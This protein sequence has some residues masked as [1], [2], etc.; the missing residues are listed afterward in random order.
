M[1]HMR[2]LMAS[3]CM[4]YTLTN[5]Y[6]WPQNGVQKSF[7]IGV[8]EADWDHWRLIQVSIRTISNRRLKILV[9]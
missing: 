1:H 2:I 7:P 3:Y 9:L 5:A 6:W 4:N 8:M